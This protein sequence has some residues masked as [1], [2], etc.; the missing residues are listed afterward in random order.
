MILA[1]AILQDGVV[2]TLPPPA[3]HHD[4]IHFMFDQCNLPT[5]IQGI[6]GFVATESVFV[7][8]KQAALVAY[9]CEQI[10]DVAVSQELYSEDLW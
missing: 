1:A 10:P 2:Y 9:K 3:R 4:I 8:R 7:C 5:P 6:Q